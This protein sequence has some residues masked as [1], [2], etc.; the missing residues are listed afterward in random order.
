MSGCFYFW[1]NINEFRFCVFEYVDIVIACIKT[2]LNIIDV[3][4]RSIRCRHVLFAIQCMTALH[5]NGSQLRQC[6][7]LHSP[8]IIFTKMK[9]KFIELVHGH[10]VQYSFYLF[11]G[12]KISGNVYMQTPV[13]KPWLV[14][15]FHARNIKCFLFCFPC[16][17][18]RCTFQ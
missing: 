11:F 16:Y 5:T 14:F 18:W 7:Y 8:R 3:A 10:P 9:M 2:T 15:Y 4:A 6:R 1:N 17:K 12:L 13:P